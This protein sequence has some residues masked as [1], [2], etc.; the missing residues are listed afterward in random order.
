M[1]LNDS[2]RSLDNEGNDSASRL[3]SLFNLV[4]TA[5]NSERNERDNII[6]NSSLSFEQR[7][8]EARKRLH[9]G[10][11][12]RDRRYRFKN[13]KRC[14]V[15]SEVVDFMIQSG[16]AK[17]RSDAVRI[18]RLLQKEFNLFEHVVDPER[19]EFDDKYLF[20]KFNTMD[21]SVSNIKRSDSTVASED[22]EPVLDKIT[23]VTPS[24]LKDTK[25]LGLVSVGGILRRGINQKFNFTLDKQGFYANDAV[26]YMVSTGLAN[27]RKD[28]EVIGLALQNVDG[29]IQ[30]V[31]AI[32]EPFQDAK[33]FFAFSQDSS[34]VDIPPWHQDLQ[35]VRTF[36][37]SNIKL[38]DHTYRLKT[39]EKT[40]TGKE[41]VDLLLIAGITS[42]RQDAVLLGR[43][44]MV[45]FNIFGHVCDEHEFE[46]SDL[47][48]K[49]TF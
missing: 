14:F 32:K 37:V 30:N 47:F 16:W 27:S 11:E 4:N 1:S 10:V 39:Y 26:D 12:V 20:Y 8:E 45:E 22:E 21:D 25:R 9:H 3:T 46:D 31:K 5:D 38:T 35:K 6:H 42:S 44:L 48:Y 18:G 23:Q 13:Y 19:H 29:M 34:Q 2:Y 24:L 15:G 33:I 40:F 41:A 7:R 43:A 28:A 49:M 17:S 36:F